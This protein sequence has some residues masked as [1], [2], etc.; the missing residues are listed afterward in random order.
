MSAP[1]A[2]ARPGQG[3]ITVLL[4][5]AAALDLARCGLVVATA[6]PPAPAPALVAVGLAAA[7]LSAWTARGC[8]AS[9]RW[10]QCAAFLIGVASAPQASASGFHAPYTIPDTATAVLG[11]LLTVTIL[12]TAGHPGQTPAQPDRPAASR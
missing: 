5:A 3:L 9:R 2:G 12:A 6:R 11:V 8:R 7:G 4:L 1:S 10:S